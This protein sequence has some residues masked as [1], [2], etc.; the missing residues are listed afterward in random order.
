MTSARGTAW[1]VSQ[2]TSI[3]RCTL[4]DGWWKRSSAISVKTAGGNVSGRMASCRGGMRDW[5]DYP[6]PGVPEKLNLD[7]AR[8]TNG[9]S[10]RLL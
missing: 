1:A 3:R 8:Y 7:H 6:L 2:R 9:I 5:S 4:G 10:C